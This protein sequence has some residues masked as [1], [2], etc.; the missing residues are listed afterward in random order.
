MIVRWG[1]DRYPEVLAELGIDE[2]L[3][4]TTRRWDALDI[5]AATVHDV[6]R[7]E[8][9]AH[10]ALRIALGY[11]RDGCGRDPSSDYV[12]GHDYRHAGSRIV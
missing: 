1:L 6:A 3:L 4:I 7:E 11:A 9:M 10:Q 8:S 12:L 2:P 5:P